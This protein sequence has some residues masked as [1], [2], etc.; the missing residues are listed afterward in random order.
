MKKIFI[1]ILYIVFLFLTAGA[2][3]ILYGLTQYG[4]TNGG[5]TILRLQAPGNSLSALQNFDLPDGFGIGFGG[6]TIQA[7]DGKLYGMSGSGGKYNQ[8]TIFSY[9]PASGAYA[10][11]KHFTGTDGGNPGGHLFKASNGKLYGMT[12][13]GG[14]NGSGPGEIFSFDPSTSTYTVL[15][16]FAGSD[17]A[18]PY[19]NSFIQASD[20][21]LYGMTQ[22]GGSS[23]GGVIF[24]FDPSTNAYTVIKNLDGSTG[25]LA[26]NNLVQA[27]DGKLYGTTTTGTLFSVDPGTFVFTL[28]A[29]LGGSG[30]TFG[31]AL[32][33][34]SNGKLYGLSEGGGASNNGSIFSFDPVSLT[35]ATVKSFSGADGSFP[36]ANGLIIANDGKMY[37]TTYGGGAN[38]LG[39]L[40][41]FDPISASYTLIKSFNGTDGS[42][43]DGTLF[44]ASN[45]KLYGLA[46]GGTGGGVL[47]SSTLSGTYSIV[48]TFGVNNL[49]NAPS[50]TMLDAGNGNFYGMTSQG[51]KYGAGVIY[52]YNLAS[53]AYTVIRHFDGTTGGH[54]EGSFLQVPGGK[55]YGLTTYGGNNND[56]VI[57]SFDPSTTTYSVLKNFDGTTGANPYGSL[58]VANNGKFYGAARNGGNS[59]NGVL[60]SFD[61]STS[62]YTVVKYLDGTTGGNPN[63]LVKGIDGKLY[64]LTTSGG[65]NSLGVLFSFDPST[66]A[67]TVLKNFDQTTGTQPQSGL[68]QASDGKFYGMQYQGGTNQDGVIFSYDASTNVFKVLKNFT[69]PDG[70]FPYGNL[71]QASD[72]K[73]YGTTSYG[74]SNNDGVAFSLDIINSTYSKLGDLSPATGDGT[75]FGT[76]FIELTA[77]PT[78]KTQPLS[79]NSYCAGAAVNVTYKVTGSYLNGNSFIAQLSDATGSFNSPVSIGSL[80]SIKNGVISGVIPSTTPAGNAYRIRVVSSGPQVTANDNGTN[81]VISL[82]PVVSQITGNNVLIAP[83]TTT[84]S[85]LTANGK[86]SSSNNSIA[87][88]DQTG[89]V[90]GNKSGSITIQYTVTNA[91]GCT[92]SA[93]FVM[94]IDNPLSLSLSNAPIQCYGMNTTVTATAKGGSGSFQYSLNN[95]GY[96]QSNTFTVTAGQ[97]TVTVQDLVDGQSVTSSINITQPT[98]FF[99]SVTSWSPTSGFGAIWG[100]IIFNNSSGGTP[101]YSYSIDGGAHYQSSP[102]FNKLNHGSYTLVVRDANNCTYKPYTFPIILAVSEKLNSLSVTPESQIPTSPKMTVYPNPSQSG[103]NILVDGNNDDHIEITVL[104]VI[105]KMAERLSGPGNTTYHFG[106]MLIKGTYFVKVATSNGV[107]V[108]KVIKL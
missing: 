24:S 22:V 78:L 25:T 87:T 45:G 46:S 35:L 81:I 92:A 10:I 74:G 101:P 28:L 105:G 34:A 32:V 42:G 39:V 94:T 68:I 56:G 57:F 51:G 83:N 40:F 9:D 2:Q 52:S 60:F 90:T 77:Q 64:G 17:G 89:T 72:S 53:A 4:G 103:F 7:N 67:Y 3:P 38:N 76:A 70:S 23:N 1:T 75:S 107:K 80:K 73:L 11:V 18:L 82:L 86:W 95:G 55:M 106:E 65:T 91:A 88:I 8:G 30:T 58:V 108:F 49:G 5:G 99:A 26:N 79:T 27:S 37:G 31:T 100:G 16:Y 96:Q 29:N 33:Q 71:M 6:Q 21:K 48:H 62:T 13:N 36:L 20:G 93:S 97:Y 54:P 69:G 12:E 66:N 104:D 85:D 61:P 98:L 19:C 43:P 59:F 44:Q 84:L 41:S 15:K 102:V 14:P 63:D 50:G 47:F